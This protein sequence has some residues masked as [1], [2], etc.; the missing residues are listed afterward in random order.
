M[1]RD[2]R[3][4][5]QLEQLLGGL[6]GLAKSS[7]PPRQTSESPTIMSLIWPLLPSLRPKPPRLLE[8]L[9]GK[10][11][12]AEGLGARKSSIAKRL[13]EIEHRIYDVLDSIEQTT[14]KTDDLNKEIN[15]LYESGKLEMT[16]TDLI[17]RLKSLIQHKAKVEKR[18]K[19]LEEYEGRI[20]K[21][22]I[23]AINLVK[24]VNP[25]FNGRNN[26]IGEAN[27]NRVEQKENGGTSVDNEQNQ[28]K[29]TLGLEDETANEVGK[30]R[31]GRSKGSLKIDASRIDLEEKEA[32][33]EDTL[34]LNDAIASE[35][36]IQGEGS[37]KE[38]E[39]SSE[40]DE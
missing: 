38:K 22:L 36:E 18:V 31:E 2:D 20:R 12:R 29:T 5:R 14:I 40:A 10:E 27:V 28:F 16:D 37:S 8:D 24:E 3:V 34:G 6:M 13:E 32:S 17:D 9:L 26:Q 11:C 30:E 4:G 15:R 39:V 19:S 23:A 1:A 35:G 21:G 7:P 25:D 33:R